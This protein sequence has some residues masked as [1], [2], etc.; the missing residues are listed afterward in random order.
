MWSWQRGGSSTALN[1]SVE[2]G[3]FSTA[4]RY[5]LAFGDAFDAPWLESHKTPSRAFCAGHWRTFDLLVG[6]P[7]QRSFEDPLLGP[8]DSFSTLWR[9][10]GSSWPVAG[11]GE[12]NLTFIYHEAADA[13]E[14]RTSFPSGLAESGGTP[15]PPLSHANELNSTMAPLSEFP[16][17]V[18]RRGLG[19]LEWAGAHSHAKVS[20]G[21]DLSS[22][23]GG[24]EGG[25]LVL[26]DAD[27]DAHAADALVLSTFTQHLTGIL[28]LRRSGFLE[29]FFTKDALVGGM[30]PGV[31]SVPPG[32]ALSF[33][34]V[35]ARGR[36]VSAAVEAWGGALRLAYDLAGANRKTNDARTDPTTHRI[37]YWTDNGGYYF[38]G[39]PMNATDAGAL[40]SSIRAAGLPPIG[41]VQL[42]P[43]AWKGY[44]ASAELHIGPRTV[45]VGAGDMN[46]WAAEPA[47][48]PGG[49]LGAYSADVAR[50][51]LLLYSLFWGGAANYSNISFTDSYPQPDLTRPGHERFLRQPAASDSFALHDRVFSEAEAQQKGG[52]GAPRLLGAFEV[53][54]LDWTIFRWP[55]F[56]ETVDGLWTWAD[57][58][59]RAAKLHGISIQ[60]APHASRTTPAPLS[61]PSREPALMEKRM[62]RPLFSAADEGGLS[63][64]RGGAPPPSSEA[65]KRLVV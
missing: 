2:S 15:Q 39:N 20:Y 5:S 62:M 50:S 37:G 42:D 25:P 3:R 52:A 8:T 47:Y 24:R 41:Y 7:E 34:V 16:R 4:L 12:L 29:R 60:Y 51:P 1:V 22:F 13:F 28:H 23:H 26:F 33:T 17:F 46:V 59:A 9:F 54:F 57:G 14:F 44:V 10:S 32:F 63:P 27:A 48:F 19:Y 43:W 35:G 6:Q 40:F 18:V 49:D 31:Q 30:Q 36:G 55:Q 21:V 56:V 58:M 64:M 38:G 53:D 45:W 11:C 65:Q 61:S